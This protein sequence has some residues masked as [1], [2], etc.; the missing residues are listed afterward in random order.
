MLAVEKLAGLAGIESV[1]DYYYAMGVASSDISDETP[2]DIVSRDSK[3]FDL[4]WR[5]GKP[6]KAIWSVWETF[7][8]KVCAF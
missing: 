8:P 2:S 6:C 7:S 3:L 4:Q 5:D 1:E